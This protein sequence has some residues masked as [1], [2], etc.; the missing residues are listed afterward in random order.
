M[1]NTLVKGQIQSL[2]TDLCIQPVIKEDSNI[3]T[4]SGNELADISLKLSKYI[5]QELPIDQLLDKTVRM[6]GEAGIAE[7][8][9]L[10]Q[11]DKKGTKSLLSNY[12][13]SPYIP[14]FNPV[15]FELDLQDS[16]LFK[17]FH[18]NTNHTLQIEDFT[19]YLALPNYLFR[20]K[21]KA[22]FLKLRTKSLLI[23]TG[24]TDNIRV[25]L[26]LQFCTRDVIWSNEIEKVFQSV[27]DQLAVAIEQYSEKRK[28]ELLQKNIIQLQESAIREQ[29]ELFRQFASDVHDLPCSIIPNLKKA[30]NDKDF[31][32]CEKLVDELHKNLR[33]LINEYVIPDINLLGFIG[34]MYQ[35]VNGFKKSFKGKVSVELPDEEITLSQRNAVEL[36]KV[37]KEW[38]CNIEKHSEA[39]EVSFTIKI[40]NENYF[41]LSI[42]DNGKG[43]DVN[44]TKN[45]GYGIL[46]LERRLRAIKSKFEIK[47]EMNKGAMLNIQ[48]P[49]N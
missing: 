10:F 24:S 38:F 21:L 15:G 6:L 32:E 33:Q 3:I 5:R 30:I 16:S 34:T 40:L 18:L 42:Q 2:I 37:V 17:L 22:L 27:I 36:F 29:E 48:A 9:L 31:K 46:N 8:V 49:V 20:N 39:T 47:S 4:L 1:E 14:K 25:A 35:F 12:W 28:K 23:T 44:N 7:R 11:I 41:L 19:K 45:L 26:N 43:F 13:E